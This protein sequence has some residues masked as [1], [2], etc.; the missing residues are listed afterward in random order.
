MASSEVLEDADEFYRTNNLA[1]AAF[2]RH[3]GH[4][5]QGMQWQGETCFW[6]FDKS[7]PLLE[8]VDKF[9]KGDALV[10]PRAY[11][12]VFGQIRKELF[13]SPEFLARAGHPYRTD[14]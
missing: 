13:D 5:H 14:P 7:D 1:L 11:N 9:F 3:Q 6:Y 10:E 8:I 4:A 12:K 2:L